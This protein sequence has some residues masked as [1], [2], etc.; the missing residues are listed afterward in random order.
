LLYVNEYYIS[1]CQTGL[2]VLKVLEQLP[3]GLATAVLA[4]SRADFESHVLMLPASLHPLAVE[5]AFPS[6]RQHNSLTLDLTFLDKLTTAYAVLDTATKGATIPCALKSLTL[7]NIPVSSN[8][9]FQHLISAACCSASYVKLQFTRSKAQLVP[10]SPLF[11]HLEESLAQNSALTSLHLSFKDDPWHVFHLDCLFQN[12]TGL[13]SLDLASHMSPSGTFHLQTPFNE[14]PS[15]DLSAKRGVANLCSLTRLR[16]GPGFHLRE[17][18]Q[19][20]PNMTR[21]QVLWLWGHELETQAGIA[22]CT[23]TTL[24]T[25]KLDFG[26]SSVL[27]PSVVTLTALQTL[28][29]KAVA[30][31]G[32]YLHLMP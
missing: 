24:H 29:L 12:L 4:V 18:A 23:L 16:L 21:L 6:I 9:R 10:S 25:L 28:D 31:L 17:L 2:S 19:V 27:L 11:S 3:E 15:H 32:G 5:A 22:L 26:Y 13:Q 14:I 30:C 1:L 7:R 8:D 20:L